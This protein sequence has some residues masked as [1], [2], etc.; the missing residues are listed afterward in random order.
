[1]LIMEFQLVVQAT[2]L[3]PRILTRSTPTLCIH[4]VYSILENTKC[5][6][7]YH[8]IYYPR[9]YGNIA[10]IRRLSIYSHPLSGYKEMNS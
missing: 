9:V 8:V 7:T 5:L 4:D 2:R 1:M 6:K 3:K 10:C